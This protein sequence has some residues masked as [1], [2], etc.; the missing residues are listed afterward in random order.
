MSV[1]GSWLGILK[2]ANKQVMAIEEPRFAEEARP[3]V[4]TVDTQQLL[5]LLVSQTAALK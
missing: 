1:C 3:A 5:Q 4:A 2:V